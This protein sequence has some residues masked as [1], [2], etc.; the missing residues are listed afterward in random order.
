MIKR[1]KTALACVLFAA[2]SIQAAHSRDI[3]VDAIY[4][5]KSS[6]VYR[7][8]HEKKMGVY[9]EISSTLI[10]SGVAHAVWSTGNDIVYVKEAGP[11]NIIYVYDRKNLRRKELGRIDG[12]VTSALMS[13]SG[14]YLFLKQLTIPPSGEPASRRIIIAAATGRKSVS[15]SSYPFMD[16]SIVPGSDSI[17]RHSASGIAEFD[18]DLGTERTILDLSAYRPVIAPNGVTIPYYSPNRKKLLVI[19]GSGGEYGAQVFYRGNKSPVN[20]ITSASE[21]FW[22]DNESIIFRVGSMG[23]FGARV[24]NVK[25]GRTDVIARGSLNTNIRFSPLPKIVSLLINQV[26]HIYDHRTGTL[27]NCGIEGEDASFS[28]DGIRFIT[29]LSGKLLMTSLDTLKGSGHILKKNAASL[30]SLYREAEK[31][32]RIWNNEF[33]RE[34]I[35][36]KISAYDRL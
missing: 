36:K 31:N 26:L 11:V 1:T 35:R 33:S 22:L 5:S 21:V 4:I 17:I 19:S 25:T 3:D 2:L 18:P 27:M 28:P 8:L 34:Y 13:Q 29:L 23:D 7:A 30:T 14:R 20:G 32:P 6:P 15:P 10:D 12:T 9:Q 16:F 24:L